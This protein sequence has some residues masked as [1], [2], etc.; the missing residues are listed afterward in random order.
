MVAAIKAKL[1]WFVAGAI[2]FALLYA[3]MLWFRGREKVTSV[4]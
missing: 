3:A 1:L 2:G 4:E